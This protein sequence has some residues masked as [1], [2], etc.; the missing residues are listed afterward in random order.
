MHVRLFD[1]HIFVFAYTST[2]RANN[3]VKNPRDVPLRAEAHSRV[4]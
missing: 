2:E 4:K 3:N 1:L